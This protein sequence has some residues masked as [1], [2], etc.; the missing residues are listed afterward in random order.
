MNWIKRLF[1]KKETTKQCDIHIES[2]FIE[3][4][5]KADCIKHWHNRG[6]N[7]EGMVVS[8]KSVYELWEVLEKYRSFRHSL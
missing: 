4:F 2:A 1:G 5:D 6:K 7:D 8:S 3:I